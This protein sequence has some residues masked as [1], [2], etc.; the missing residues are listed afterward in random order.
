MPP[1]AVP[2]VVS[3]NLASGDGAV[4]QEQVTIAQV[5]ADEAAGAR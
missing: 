1:S 5:A 4:G 3:G 2:T